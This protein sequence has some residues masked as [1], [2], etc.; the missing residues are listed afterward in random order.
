MVLYQATIASTQPAFR[1]WPANSAP[2]PPG[3]SVLETVDSE[4]AALFRAFL[5]PL[6]DQSGSW[7]AL[8]ETMRANGYGLAFRGGKLCLT[9]HDNGERLCSL[10][11]LGMA[12]PDLV[13]RLGR[14]IVR[15]L[16]GGAANGD[17][18]IATP[19]PYQA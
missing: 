17:L 6:F 12:L 14:P 3:V 13:A 4:T 5:R 19:A 1:S 10:N 16:P 18:L 9:D 11:F 2:H 7:P 8:M 15:A